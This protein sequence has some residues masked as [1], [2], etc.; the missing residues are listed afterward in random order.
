MSSDTSLV[1]KAKSTLGVSKTTAI[2][3]WY[4]WVDAKSKETAEQVRKAIAFEVGHIPE[5]TVAIIKI[6]IETALRA[7]GR[8]IV[9]TKLC[10]TIK[11]SP[12]PK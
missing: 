11:S 1:E 7:A 2:V 9:T 8:H 5:S 3:E 10:D 12:E 4:D 6:N